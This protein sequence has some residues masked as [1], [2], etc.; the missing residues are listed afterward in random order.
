MWLHIRLN[1][2]ICVVSFEFCEA[3]YSFDPLI[4]ILCLRDKTTDVSTKMF[5]AAEFGK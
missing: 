4:P 5:I 3:V 2:G 1:V